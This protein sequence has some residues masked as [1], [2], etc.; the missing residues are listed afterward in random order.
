[1]A[2]LEIS[3]FQTIHDSPQFSIYYLYC[4]GF[5][6]PVLEDTLEWMVIVQVE[7]DQEDLMY[8]F[9]YGYN[10]FQLEKIFRTD[11]H[12]FGLDWTLRYSISSR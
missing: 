6:N 2:R 1:M 8:A 11:D 4:E 3:F 12:S 7:E 5:L 10:I 9:L